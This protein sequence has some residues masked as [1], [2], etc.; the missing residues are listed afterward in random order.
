MRRCNGSG[1]IIKLSG[2]RRKPWAVR[3]PYRNEQGRVRQRYL[4]YH[5]KAAEAQAA[6]DEWCRTHT[7]P[8]TDRANQ[9]LQ[10]VYDAW[11]A[12][13]YPKIGPQAQDSHRAAWLR[14]SHLGAKRIRDIGIDDLQGCLDLALEAGLAPATV[15]KIRVT[16]RSLMAYAMQRDIIVKD[17]S[18]YVQLPAAGA[19][20]EKNALS[21]PQLR[22]LEQLAAAGVPM[23]DT[24]LILCYT[25]FRVGEL[26]DLT[27][28]AYQSEGGVDYL[29]G[30]KKTDA[31]RD[32][33]V[34]VH[35]KIRP[36][37]LAWLARKGDRIVCKDDGGAWSVSG[38]RKHFQIVVD[39]LGC[40]QATP[41]WCRYTMASLLH[42]A[43]ADPLAVR[44]ILGHADANITDHYTQLTPAQLAA[45][46]RKVS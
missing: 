17:Y 9:T 6:L 10:Q 19:R 3:V 15:G 39:A 13:K 21:E 42:H 12:W 23:A 2:A 14:L 20:Q 28:F 27:P 7:A 35:P 44:R 26:L 40:P 45:E 25:G 4:S 37:L 16:M 43:N 33:V 36:Y 30:G 34:P 22:R 41:H 5:A 31:G 18:Q 11:A 32:R 24:V 46:L 8:E 29:V 38:Y 1:N